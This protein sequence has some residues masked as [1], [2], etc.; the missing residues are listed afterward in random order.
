M[1]NVKK[2]WIIAAISLLIVGAIIFTGAMTALDFDFTK[3]STEK[4]ETNSYEVSEDFSK[5]SIDVTTAD[6]VLAS[7]DNENCKVVCYEQK[8]LKHS[9]AVKDDTLIIDTID[10][11]KWYDYLGIAFEN[12]KMTVYL[13]QD[14]Y[15]SL[16]INTATGDVEI[17]KNF[18]FENIDVTSAT[19]DA[20]CYA[21]ASDTIKIETD[22]GDIKVDTIS[23]KNIN[24]FT[25]TGNINMNTVTS[26]GLV[27]AE[28]DTGKIKST[29]MNC[30]SFSA[31]SH[32]GNIILN[33][34]I[35]SDNF[36]IESSTGDVK[37]DRSD[38]STISVK[39]NTGDITGTLLSEKVF[40]TKTSTGD[41]SVP[42]TASGGICDIKTQTGDIEIDIQ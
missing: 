34:V 19:A 41:I 9:I 36:T 26:E 16:L 28:T 11:R 39:S 3:L 7:S 18:T 42:K 6:I 35:A 4:Y 2:V 20:F 29:D 10:T 25:A 27:Y 37:F 5:I 30:K 24:L 31:D 8:K 17:P 22:T 32:T 21:S 33:N 1:N 23:A 13:P 14:K 15:T 12:M 38:A 40:I